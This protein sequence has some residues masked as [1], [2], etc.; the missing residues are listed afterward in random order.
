MWWLIYFSIVVIALVSTVGVL[1]VLTEAYSNTL[2]AYRI[3][4][5]AL[6]QWSSLTSRL[7]YTICLAAESR[8]REAV[9]TLNI[10]KYLELGALFEQAMSKVRERSL[11]KRLNFSW[12]FW[13]D[14]FMWN[15]TFRRYR[16]G[17]VIDWLR[18]SALINTVNAIRGTSFDLTT[19]T[20]Y[21][22]LKPLVPNGATLEGV[23]YGY[24]YGNG[25]YT[26]YLHGDY[27]LIDRRELKCTDGHISVRFYAT[28]YAT[29]TVNETSPYIYV[30]YE[31]SI[32]N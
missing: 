23:I 25:T 31:I 17:G 11:L 10:S 26:G 22:V 8:A 29:L 2:E 16:A 7:N 3:A 5:F 1:L 21:D 15:V 20:V 13:G 28:H 19:S 9:G 12:A 24:L 6:D 14:V 30:Y 18:P 4:K 32:N 27:V